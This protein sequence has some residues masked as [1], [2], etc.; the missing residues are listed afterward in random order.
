MFNL[1]ILIVVCEEIV[2][3]KKY[4]LFFQIHFNKIVKW[5]K[6]DESCTLLIKKMVTYALVQL[7]KK[8]VLVL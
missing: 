2:L 6:L 7:S 4:D 8:N 3:L 1:S 5:H